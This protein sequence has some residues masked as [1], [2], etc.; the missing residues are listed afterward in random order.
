MRVLQLFDNR[1]VSTRSNASV[2]EIVNGEDL[3]RRARLR[4]IIVT[5]LL[6]VVGLLPALV[7]I[8][9]EY[10]MLVAFRRKWTDV[11]LQRKRDGLDQRARCTRIHWLG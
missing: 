6:I 3:K 4:V 1:D 7:K 2:L 10:S 5:V 9:R 11:H 8:L